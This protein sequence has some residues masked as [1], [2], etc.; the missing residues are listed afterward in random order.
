MPLVRLAQRLAENPG[1]RPQGG[2]LNLVEVPR[3]NGSFGNGEA[4]SA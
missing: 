2:L 3:E 4:Q 1:L